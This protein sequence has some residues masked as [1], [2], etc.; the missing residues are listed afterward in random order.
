LNKFLYATAKLN[1]IW[2]P[3]QP[4]K[5]SFEASTNFLDDGIW[6]RAMIDAGGGVSALWSPDNYSE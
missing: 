1:L 4:E 2:F 3:Q 5:N 6:Q